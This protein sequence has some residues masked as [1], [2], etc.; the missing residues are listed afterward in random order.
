M[1]T[2]KKHEAQV[3]QLC[4]DNCP[5]GKNDNYHGL[6]SIQQNGGVTL[7]LVFQK[8]PGQSVYTVSPSDVSTCE[9]NTDTL[10]HTVQAVL[11]GSNH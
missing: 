11:A 6:Y 8:D 5:I 9:I 10:T 7:D 2:C 3:K 4:Q 1:N